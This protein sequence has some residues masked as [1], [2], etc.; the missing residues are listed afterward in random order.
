MTVY[1]IM[2]SKKFDQK[3]GHLQFL[4]ETYVPWVTETY[5][6]IRFKR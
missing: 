5:Y 6:S 4:N 2:S 3:I 1:M